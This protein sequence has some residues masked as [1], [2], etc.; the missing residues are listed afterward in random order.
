M[1]KNDFLFELC[2]IELMIIYFNVFEK[3]I[4][5]TLKTTV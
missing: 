4:L 5:L 3:T 1:F 2:V